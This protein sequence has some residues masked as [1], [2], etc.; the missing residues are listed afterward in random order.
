MHINIY[1]N[2]S[3]LLNIL[4]G[5]QECPGRIIIM[6][7]N[8]P[9]KLDKALIRPGHIDYNIN[10]TKATIDDIINIIK[11]YWNIDNDIIINKL[12]DMIYTHAEIINLCR[13]SNTYIDFLNSIKF[14]N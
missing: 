14:K 4:D 11:F 7:T 1:N 2:L 6:T 13:I 12:N 9:E 8:K 5:I 10:F 3:Y